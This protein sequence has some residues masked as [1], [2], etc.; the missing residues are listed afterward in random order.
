MS[1]VA[2]AEGSQAR[3]AAL[4]DVACCLMIADPA[5]RQATLG[6]H[7]RDPASSWKGT[8]VRKGVRAGAQT[9]LR[10]LSARESCKVTEDWSECGMKVLCLHAPMRPTMIKPAATLSRLSH[11]WVLQDT[12]AVH[13]AKMDGI[14]PGT[15]V[16]LCRCLLYGFFESAE[17]ASIGLRRAVKAHPMP[18]A[19][20]HEPAWCS[21]TPLDRQGGIGQAAGH[22]QP[23]RGS[24]VAKPERSLRA[25]LSEMLRVTG[26]C[27]PPGLPALMPATH[28]SACNSTVRLSLNLMHDTV[29]C[30]SSPYQL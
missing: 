16:M 21:S 4:A 11:R 13:M 8:E 6:T 1:P 28:H 2:V 23:I 5:G 19:H 10:H 12:K 14:T 30:E 24:G 3:L 25:A 18:D 26:T 29:L 9:P 20:V 22:V 7:P 15:C 17:A 27:C